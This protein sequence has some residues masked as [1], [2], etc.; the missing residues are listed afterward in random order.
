MQ[1]TKILLNLQRLEWLQILC[2]PIDRKNKIFLS[3]MALN[4]IFIV[5]RSLQE[6][7]C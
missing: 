7:I 1:G 3:R 4:E 2:F 6:K 5:L